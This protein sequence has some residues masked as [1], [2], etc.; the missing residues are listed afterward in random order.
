M[1][2]APSYGISGESKYKQESVSNFKKH[3]T[4]EK[5]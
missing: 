2:K 1:R 4:I 3:I 5:S